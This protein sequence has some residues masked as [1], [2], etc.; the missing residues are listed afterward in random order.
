MKR[1][2]LTLIFTSSFAFLFGQNE[3]DINFDN[4]KS[5]I[6]N[7]ESEYY[8]SKLLSRFNDFDSTLTQQEYALIYYGFSFQE[9]YIK[10]KPSETKLGKL[11]KKEDYEAIIEEC[12]KILKK[13]PVS[14]KANN[15]MGYTLYK[16][17]KLQ[18]EWGK[19]QN[20]YRAI[21]KVIAYSGNGISKETAFKVIYV[22][23]EYNMLYS[24]FHI[25]KI[26][27]QSLV[28]LCD[29]FVIEPSDYY[30]VSEVYFNISRKLL[31]T[32]EMLNNK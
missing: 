9:D 29:K 15:E 2:L 22:E 28:G 19:Y 13:N 1:I 17:Q 25:S 12:Q 21:R 16:L 24:Y 20:R 14:L 23:D 4:I 3:L 18:G 5:T 26:Y 11:A 6:E 30:Q 27:E 8:Y 31:R 10:N 7:P 32:N